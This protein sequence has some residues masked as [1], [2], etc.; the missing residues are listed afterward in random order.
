MSSDG[1]VTKDGRINNVD[2]GEGKT[3]LLKNNILRDFNGLCMK[4][5]QN[6]TFIMRLEP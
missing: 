5:V 4:I 6:V 2:S 1:R 3:N